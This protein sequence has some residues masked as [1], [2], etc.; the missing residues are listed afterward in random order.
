MTVETIGIVGVLVLT[1]LL[2]GLRHFM[3][4]LGRANKK[5]NLAIAPRENLN[6]RNNAFDDAWLS[7]APDF[8]AEAQRRTGSYEDYGH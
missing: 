5:R 4:T 7:W 6:L 8:E 2:F 3:M 1:F